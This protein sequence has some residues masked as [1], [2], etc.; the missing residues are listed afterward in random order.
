M[1]S[2]IGFVFVVNSEK[3]FGRFVKESA[4]KEEM[5][6]CSSSG[7]W[8]TSHLEQLSSRRL[9]ARRV[10]WSVKLFDKI[11][12]GSEF[13]IFYLVDSYIK[14]NIL[15]FSPAPQKMLFYL[16]PGGGKVSQSVIPVYGGVLRNALTDITVYLPRKNYTIF[17]YQRH[18]A[19]N[20]RSTISGAGRELV[21]SCVV[22]TVT[23]T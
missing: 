1:K 6:S 23:A 18:A 22:T 9:R 10:S 20:R 3:A 21:G 11:C 13:L 2:I 17:N 15:F 4:G 19:G 7:E 16:F 8:R 14:P 5:A 12:R